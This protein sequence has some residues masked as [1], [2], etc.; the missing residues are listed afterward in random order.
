[1]TSADKKKS[2]TKFLL[3][4]ALFWTLIV[5]GI[6]VF[7]G[8]KLY[9]QVRSTTFP[10]TSGVIIS[11]EVKHQRGSKG[12][13]T[14]GVNISYSYEV[15]GR[16]YEGNTFRYTTFSSSNSRNAY[17][18]VRN[19][20]P[21]K[22]VKVYYNPEN[23]EDS[24]LSPGINGDDLFILLFLTPF[25]LIMVALLSIPV[26]SLLRKVK[27]P[28]AG[29]VKWWLDGR[30]IY[31]RLPRFSTFVGLCFALGIISFVCVFIVAFG[32]GDHPSLNSAL[33]VWA[34]IIFVALDVYIWLWFTQGGGKSDLVIDPDRR[35]VELPQ[36]FGRTRRQT[37]SIND[38]TGVDVEV[39]ETKSS[40]GVST[41]KY[42]TSLRDKDGAKYTIAEW[43]DE[44][45]ASEFA[46]W[47]RS[48]LELNETPTPPKL[49]P[50]TEPPP[51]LTS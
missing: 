23:P 39:V 49:Y 14:Y 33:I 12:G 5:G 1:M 3:F 2:Q 37:I 50:G 29:G 26:F 7:F 47:L 41:Q 6:D 4:F 13:T 9:R 48:K 45:D 38:I 42:V 16:R 32:M 18:T 15:A 34:V 31:V 30:R 17:Q 19:Y 35:I 25:N 11:S 27:R 10:S 43:T 20:P 51:I 44:E 46:G 22:T 28:D 8:Y 21:G 24:L 40:R 36:T